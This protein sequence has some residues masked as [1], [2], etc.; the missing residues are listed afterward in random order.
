[1]P[2]GAPTKCVNNLFTR[3]TV[4]SLR[5]T[6][7]AL[8]GANAKGIDGVSKKEYGENPE[9]NMYDQVRRVHNGSFKPQAKREAHILKA[10][11]RPIRSR[12][13]ALRTI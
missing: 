7:R 12:S 1:M 2:P 3:N 6:Y 9:E 8:D 13:A 4:K 5:E 10:N 11:E